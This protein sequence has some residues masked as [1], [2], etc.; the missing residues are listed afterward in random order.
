MHVYTYTHICIYREDLMSVYIGMEDNQHQAFSLRASPPFFLRQGFSFALDLPNWIRA[1]NFQDHHVS[2][3][4]ELRC[5]VPLN[6]I[7]YRAVRVCCS[8]SNF[9]VPKPFVFKKLSKLHDE[10]EYYRL[11]WVN[12]IFTELLKDVYWRDPLSKFHSV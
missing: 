11:H 5:Q 2:A 8:L 10:C 7:L 3:S 1:I 6:W 4:S 9:S 12:S